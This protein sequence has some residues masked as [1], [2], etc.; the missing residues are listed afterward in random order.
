[1]AFRSYV[2]SKRLL[3]LHGGASS[4]F[5]GLDNGEIEEWNAAGEVEHTYK[6]H[7]SWILCLL[8]HAGYLW[9]GSGD[10]TVRLWN[11]QTGDCVK[12]IQVTFALSS[13][14]IWQGNVVGG[15]Y[16]YLHTWNSEGQQV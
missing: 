4:L 5:L 14:C 8:E 7:T 1:M 16:S 9:S 3:S 6:G 11:I 10:E 2:T 13:F 15:G 12:T